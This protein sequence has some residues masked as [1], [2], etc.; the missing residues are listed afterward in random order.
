[1]RFDPR[2][3]IQAVRSGYW[4]I[5]SL[6]ALLAIVL[7]AVMVWLDAVTGAGWLSGIGWYQSAK[8]EGA[9]EVLSTIAG[10]MITVAGVVFS[11]TVVAIA[12]AA[13]QYGPRVLTNF[14]SDRGNQYTLGTFIATFVYCVVVLRT[15]RSGDDDGAFVPQMAVMVGLLLGLCSIGVLIYFIH[16]VPQ[17]IHLNNVVAHIGHELLKSVD[18]RFPT[19]LGDPA[20]PEEQAKDPSTAAVAAL[21]AGAA[22]A[23]VCRIEARETGYILAIDEEDLL[24][25]ARSSGLVVRLCCRPGEYVHKGRSLALAWPAAKADEDAANRLRDCYSVGNRR[26]PEGDLDFLV[27]ELVEIAARALSSGVNDPYTAMTCIDWLGAGASELAQRRY[28]SPMRLDEDGVVRVVAPAEGFLEFIER[29][30]GRMR[31]YAAR[32]MNAAVHMLA[33]LG[34]VAGSC[35][36][37]DQ[38]VTLRNEGDRLLS[39]ASKDLHEASFAAVARERAALHRRIVTAR[40]CG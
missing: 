25:A 17:S 21:E 23:S 35:R 3:F 11:I 22:E 20:R 16:H 29:G 19:L 12:Y 5:P 18:R 39:L 13:S 31:Q 37:E 30:F 34:E 33:T 38:L 36:T 28:P 32:D 26:T 10:S 27:D 15:I 2:Q 6:M 14:M 8:P 7:G 4:F 40:S 24:E 1:M 9:R